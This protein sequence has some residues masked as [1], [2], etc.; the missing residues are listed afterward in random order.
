[1]TPAEQDDDGVSK[2]LILDEAGDQLL[3]EVDDI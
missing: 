1:M 3:P 2:I